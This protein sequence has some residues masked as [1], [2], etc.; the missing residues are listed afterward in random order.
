MMTRTT[1]TRREFLKRTALATTALA[2]QP[3]RTI[4]AAV[5]PPMPTIKF[6]GA[7]GFV[8]GSSH[9]LDTGKYKI[10]LDCGKFMEPENEKY[11]GQ[12]VFD[13]RNWIW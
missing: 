5:K 7:A 8:S 13:P 2:V 11:N 1:L 3:W 9:L 10:L 4:R 12:F 6:C